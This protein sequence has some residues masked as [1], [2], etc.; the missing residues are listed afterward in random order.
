MVSK[1]TNN[2]EKI[3]QIIHYCWFGKGKKPEIFEKCIQ[4]WK[5][6]MPQ[7]QIV[8]W[9]ESNIDVSSCPFVKM[10]YENKKYAFVTDVVRLQVVY[11]YGG[12]YLDTD[13]E[14]STSLDD[15]M[16][17][18]AF[19]FFQNQ[20]QINTGQGFGAKPNNKLIKKMLDDYE[21]MEFTLENLKNIAC[22]VINTK[23]IKKSLPS[24]KSNNT[25]QH[26]DKMIFLPCDNYWPIA[27][28]YGEFSWQDEEQRKALKYANRTHKAGW[29]RKI[30]L[31]PSISFFLERHRLQLALKVYTFLVYDLV[32]YG[33]IYWIVRVYNKVKKSMGLK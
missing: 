33:I 21:N 13:V 17:Y 8:E 10:A 16:E 12:V 1:S 2:E 31:N 9:N 3:P 6:Y 28:H 14:L 32:D 25:V 11:K 18:D 24:F 15:L 7:A 30:L 23:T 29:F 27:I 5:I 26:I 22:P 4:S 20:N 19:F